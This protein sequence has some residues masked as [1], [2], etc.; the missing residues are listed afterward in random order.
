M[1]PH[2]RFPT[3]KTRSLNLERI[4]F[5]STGALVARGGSTALRPRLLDECAC[6]RDNHG[7]PHLALA[8]QLIATDC[9]LVGALVGNDTLGWLNRL[10]EARNE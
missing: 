10:T 6:Q 9:W 2:R 7:I 3:L 1:G 8:R 5:S 4:S